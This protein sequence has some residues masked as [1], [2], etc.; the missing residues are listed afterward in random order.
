VVEA[1]ESRTL[2]TATADTTPPTQWELVGTDGEYRGTATLVDGIL[3]VV[4]TAADDDIQ[5]GTNSDPDLMY[6][7]VLKMSGITQ[8]YSR[9]RGLQVERARIHGIQIDAGDGNDAIDYLNFNGLV[10]L[11]TTVNGGAGDDDLMGEFDRDYQDAQIAFRN[12]QHAYA[13]VVLSGGDGNDR[14]MARIGD[15]TLIGGAGDDQFVTNESWGHNTIVDDPP[16]PPPA[17][18]QPV[19]PPPALVPPPQ[20]VKPA[21]A[22]QADAPTASPATPPPTPFSTQP[23][24]AAVNGPAVL[25]DDRADA[26]WDVLH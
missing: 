8:D 15:A 11:P 17:K 16:A 14:L 4:T 20:D 10:N 24:T 21:P 13:P 22:P 7:V 26:P 25:G 9:V 3:H 18:P 19:A 2:L 12:Q 5:I 1:L 23:L 6:V